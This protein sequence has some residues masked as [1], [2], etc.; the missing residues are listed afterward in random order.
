MAR[1]ILYNFLVDTDAYNQPRTDLASKNDA[2]SKTRRLTIK[3][4]ATILIDGD[5]HHQ[6][7]DLVSRDR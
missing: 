6:T 5:Q 7:F 2:S 3:N 1:H 4:I